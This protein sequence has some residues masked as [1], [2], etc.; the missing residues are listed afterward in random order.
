MFPAAKHYKER[1]ASK[2]KKLAQFLAYVPHKRRS[3][4]DKEP[5]SGFRGYCVPRGCHPL[6]LSD[7]H[8]GF[9]VRSK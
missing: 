2:R 6:A 1:L 4:V 3:V 5:E 7:S 9:L 8:V